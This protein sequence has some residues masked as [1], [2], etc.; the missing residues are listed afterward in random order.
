MSVPRATA[1]RKPWS[2]TRRQ[3]S[4]STQSMTSRS[5]NRPTVSRHSRLITN[6]V[7]IASGTSPNPSG[8]IQV[9]SA[10][11]PFTASTQTMPRRVTGLPRANR[12]SAIDT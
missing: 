9:G 6:P 10:G 12:P 3:Y 2:R 4:V 11:A 1:M 8:E 5:S 7:W